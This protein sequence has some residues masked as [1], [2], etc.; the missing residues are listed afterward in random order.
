MLIFLTNWYIVSSLNVY[1]V[2][3]LFFTYLIDYVKEKQ[4]ILWNRK[5][6]GSWNFLSIDRSINQLIVAA[7]QATILW[8]EMSI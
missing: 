7:L 1:N 3:A 5:N 2:S 8:D 6:Y 4:Q